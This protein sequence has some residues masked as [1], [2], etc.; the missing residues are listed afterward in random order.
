MKALK[1]YS[2]SLGILVMAV[3][4]LFFIWWWQEPE[5]YPLGWTTSDIRAFVEKEYMTEDGRSIRL[6][7][8][9]PGQ[10]DLEEKIMLL[11][12]DFN[13]CRLY[14]RYFEVLNQF[15]AHTPDVSILGIL[16]NAT[17]EMVKTLKRGNRWSLEIWSDPWPSWNKIGVVPPDTQSF[18][19][20]LDRNP[21]RVIGVDWILPFSPI[22]LTAFPWRLAN[23]ARVPPPEPYFL[24]PGNPF[25]AGITGLWK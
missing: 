25:D 12:A 9:H 19:V 13:S 24:T 1:L 16:G 7:H 5:K 11:W 4:V 14:Y 20:V 22:E 2:W 8:F 18:I 17:P 6:A 15:A 10:R 3:T 21:W 23:L